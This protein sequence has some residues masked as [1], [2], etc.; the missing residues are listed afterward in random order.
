MAET[1]LSFHPHPSTSW[2]TA[3]SWRSQNAMGHDWGTLESLH[4]RHTLAPYGSLHA[5]K[6]SLH[7]QNV[8]SAAGAVLVA[9]WRQ[10]VGAC[11]DRRQLIQLPACFW[12]RVVGSLTFPAVALHREAGEALAPLAP[13]TSGVFQGAQSFGAMSFLHPHV[14]PAGVHAGNKLWGFPLNGF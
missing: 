12:Q 1:L 2:T 14:L 13:T 11:T 10:P 8:P 7:W 9:C 6:R 5:R 4:P 3:I